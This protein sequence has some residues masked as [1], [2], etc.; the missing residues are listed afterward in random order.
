MCVSI[1]LS[2]CGGVNA[3]LYVVAECEGHALSSPPPLPLFHCR[4]YRR[5]G[6]GGGDFVIVTLSLRISGLAKVDDSVVVA[7]VWCNSRKMSCDCRVGPKSASCPQNPRKT[8]N[9]STR[10]VLKPRMS[11]HVNEPGDG[12]NVRQYL[13]L[14]NMTTAFTKLPPLITS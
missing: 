9:T 13:Q 10:L 7:V 2:G 3:F 12:Q 4:I 11:R 6:G 1:I 14:G 5:L 8:G